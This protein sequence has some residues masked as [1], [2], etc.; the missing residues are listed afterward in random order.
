M[1]ACGRCR[2]KWRAHYLDYHLLKKLLSKAAA[3]ATAKAVASR[4]AS[5][6][7]STS[8][9]KGERASLLGKARARGGASPPPLG[10]AEFK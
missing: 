8:D 4:K 1:L 3:K 2:Q 10:A 7:T 5:P 6:R 9:P